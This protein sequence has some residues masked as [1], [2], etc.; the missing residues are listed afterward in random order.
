MKEASGSPQFKHHGHGQKE[1]G[2]GGEGAIAGYGQ[3]G[4]ITLLG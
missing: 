4:N 1:D 2:V 3:G